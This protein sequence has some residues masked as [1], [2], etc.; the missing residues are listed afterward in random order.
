MHEIL[1]SEKFSLWIRAKP[2]CRDTH[3]VSVKAGFLGAVKNGEVRSGGVLAPGDICAAALCSVLQRQR[4][5]AVS[6]N[7]K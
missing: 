6:S 7:T 2:G 3:Q 1:P 5:S 4:G